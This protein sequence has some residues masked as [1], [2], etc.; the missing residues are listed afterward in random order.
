[1]NRNLVGYSVKEKHLKFEQNTLE[2]ITVKLF[3]ILRTLAKLNSA[4]V[5][6]IRILNFVNYYLSDF[7]CK[8]SA[9]GWKQQFRVRSREDLELISSHKM[10]R[11]T[12]SGFLHSYPIRIMVPQ[13][14]SCIYSKFVEYHTLVTYYRCGFYNFVMKRI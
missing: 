13:E 8:T 14:M 4:S 2:R 12:C 10:K 9:I 5:A 7:H 3:A 1:M 6:S 11:E